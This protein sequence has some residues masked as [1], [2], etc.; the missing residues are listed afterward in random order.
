MKNTYTRKIL[1]II[2]PFFLGLFILIVYKSFELPI[3]CDDLDYL[4]LRRQLFLFTREYHFVNIQYLEAY[5]S[6]IQTEQDYPNNTDLINHKLNSAYSLAQ[7]TGFALSRI[8]R[9]EERII[10]I[11]PDYVSRIPIQPFEQY[12]RIVSRLLNS[13]N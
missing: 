2:L 8:R 10:Q 6:Y 12:H 13:G 4:Q 11:N 1:Y 9:L 7:R 3:L 5:D